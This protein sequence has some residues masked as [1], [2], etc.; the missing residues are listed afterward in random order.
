MKDEIARLWEMQKVTIIP[1][2][3]RA[4]GTITNRFGKCMQE[5]GI[6]V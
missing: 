6:D 1:V 3:V 4:L 2:V 5:I